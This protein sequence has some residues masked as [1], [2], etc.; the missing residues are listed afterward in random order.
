MTPDRQPVPI[1]YSYS[2]VFD[3]GTEKRFEFLLDEKT[4]QLIPHRNSANNPQWTALGFNQ[5][6]HCPLGSEVEYCPV[7]V[8]LTPLIDTFKDS[9]SFEGAQVTVETAERTYVKK[10]AVQKGLSSMIGLI[11]VTSGCPIM[12]KLRPMARFHLPFASGIETFYRAIS[13]YLTAQFFIKQEGGE[14]DWELKNLIGIYKEISR[15]NKGMSGRLSSAS[16][17]DANINALVILHA[18][19]EAVPFFVENGLEQ[20]ESYFFSYLKNKQR[21]ADT[22][23]S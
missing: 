17:K 7:A 2:F 13:M 14:P 6:D 21:I 20:I 18:F 3:N 16:N 5:C 22:A 4:L 1:R 12:D 19:G 9:L 8:N 11:M 23:Q 10:T 15:V